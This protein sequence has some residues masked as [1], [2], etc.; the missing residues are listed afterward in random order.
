MA[1]LTGP[2]KPDPPLIT[3]EPKP[4]TP[5]RKPIDRPWRKEKKATIEKEPPPDII[6]D[7]LTDVTFDL[8][9][10]ISS[11]S[12]RSCW[13]LGYEGLIPIIVNHITSDVVTQ[14]VKSNRKNSLHMLNFVNV[15]LTILL[16]FAM[17]PTFKSVLLQ[18]KADE[19][20]KMYLDEGCHLKLRVQACVILSC[21]LGGST[22]VFSEFQQQI[23]EHM[24]EHA[25]SSL[26]NLVSPQ[27][28][29]RWH[30]LGVQ[31]AHILMSLRILVSNEPLI[32]VMLWRN[33]APL[34]ETRLED[35]DDE[36]EH[37]QILELIFTLS[38]DENVRDSIVKG[39][40]SVMSILR[41]LSKSNQ[42]AE[43]K[44]TAL[45]LLYFLQQEWTKVEK[46]ELDHDKRP[47]FISAS[48]EKEPTI[49]EIARRLDRSGYQVLVGFENQHK[50]S[51]AIQ[52]M[53]DSMLVLVCFDENYIINPQCRFEAYV[54]SKLYK[55]R[56]C[57]RMQHEHQP[58]GWLYQQISS[59]LIIDF[60][61]VPQT[62][63]SA[64]QQLKDELLL[65]FDYYHKRGTRVKGTRK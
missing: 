48:I 24:L 1:L 37:V 7:P 33:L 53:Q 56:I 9:N 30:S 26:G 43:V 17:M 11:V 22:Q 3:V 52:A 38:F 49:A 31:S 20:M 60:S 45:R 46:H 21:I 35:N 57:L 36:E 34:I 6:T 29:K 44:I 59:H 19:A 64:M 62:F 42:K 39:K 63:E 27:N 51:T 28:G 5:K 12:V 25:E 18:N 8:I 50:I 14:F 10:I 55:R 23:V 47:I 61:L 54:M 16:R 13:I 41:K 58:V 65:H 4:E 32:T 15:I 40:T 2:K